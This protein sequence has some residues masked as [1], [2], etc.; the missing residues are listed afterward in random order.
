MA[1]K[2]R[3]TRVLNFLEGSEE[4]IHLVPDE[5]ERNKIEMKKKKKLSWPIILLEYSNAKSLTTLLLLTTS[6]AWHFPSYNVA[7]SF[8]CG[9]L[10]QHQLCPLHISFLFLDLHIPPL[11]LSLSL[12]SFCF[13]HWSCLGMPPSFNNICGSIFSNLLY[14]FL[15]IISPLAIP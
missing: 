4:M 7:Y 12:L 8:I 14:H 1:I 13:P 3:G 9:S 6:L 2:N 10:P 11:V 15:Y 5:R